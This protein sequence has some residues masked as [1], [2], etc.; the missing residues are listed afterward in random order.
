MVIAAASGGGVRALLGVLGGA[1]LVVV[2]YRAIHAGVDALVE[3]PVAGT[4]AG[5]WSLDRVAP[6]EIHHEIRYTGCNCLRYDGAFARASG[7]DAGGRIIAR[8]RRRTRGSA[9][10]RRPAPGQTS[11]GHK[12]TANRQRTV[13]R[14]LDVET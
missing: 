11:T 5:G 13:T 14:G 2:S 10:A 8:G 1:L 6:C 7:M 9:N 12:D 3:R 4:N